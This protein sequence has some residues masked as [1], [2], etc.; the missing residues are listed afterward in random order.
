MR[1]APPQTAGRGLAP[2]DCGCG[3]AGGECTCGGAQ[4]KSQLVYAIGRL[5]VSFV[6]QARRDAVWRKINGKAEGDLKPITD[7]ALQELMKREPF[8]AQ[9]VVWTLSRTEVPMYAIVPAGA[10][11][12]EAY[13]WLVEEWADKDVEFISLP[14][15]IAGQ[16]ALYDGQIVDAVIP[17]LRGMFSWDTDKY[18]KA[19][20]DGLKKANPNVSDQLLGRE[21]K[22]FFGKIYYSIRNRGLSPEERAINAAATNAFNI[23]ETIIEAGEEG[24][25]LRD[26]GVER[27]PLNRPGSEYFDVLLTFFDPEKR[28][29]RAP[30]RAR[31]T[32]DV[33]DTVPVPI[34][35]PVTWHEY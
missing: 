3:G 26:I 6:S 9:S 5:G 11:A 19:L 16:V 1:P 2:A 22:R 13:K 7:A 18:T 4:K 14:G 28:G 29:E 21:M 10:F 30:L 25:T 27:S 15:L 17:D 20:R 33:S 12:A 8:Q 34:G 23:S 24:L 31:F 32:I 35:D